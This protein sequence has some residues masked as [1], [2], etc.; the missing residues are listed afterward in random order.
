MI[1]LG[2]TAEEINFIKRLSHLLDEEVLQIDE[3][4]ARVYTAVYKIKR[5]GGRRNVPEESQAD[6]PVIQQADA[7]EEPQSDAPE[8]P[9]SDAPEEPQADAPEDVPVES[10]KVV[11]DVSIDGDEK[12]VDTLPKKKRY[13]TIYM[14]QAY[15][16]K[17]DE[18][19][20]EEHIIVLDKPSSDY[21]E[22]SPQIKKKDVTL[23]SE[24]CHRILRILSI[25]CNRL[26][27]SK[28]C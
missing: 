7:P 11:D 9:Q 17:A 24:E 26:R 15:D 2:L 12:V 27:S 16:P 19:P 14:N 10:E 6:A 5:L 20:V 22:W 25:D 18:K 1:I 13:V 23:V 28:T 8:E 4:H 3:K 21:N